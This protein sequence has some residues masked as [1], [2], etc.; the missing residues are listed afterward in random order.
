MIIPQIEKIYKD[1]DEK[2]IREKVAEGKIHT[3]GACV[4]T[5]MALN[6]SLFFINLGDCRAIISYKKGTDYE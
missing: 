1:L 6:S 5:M 4:C 3:D 2:I